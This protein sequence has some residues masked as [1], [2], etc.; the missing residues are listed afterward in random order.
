MR[1]KAFKLLKEYNSSPSLIKHA[2]AVEGVMRYFAKKAGEDEEYWGTVGLLHDID[3]E[4]YPEEHCKK[5]IDILRDNNYSED[6]IRSITSHGYGIV[7]DEKPNLY[8]EKV[9][10]SIDEL[11][12]LITATALM[13]PSK[14]VM[15]LEVKSVK[16]KFKDKGFAASIDRNI[17]RNGSEM[18]EI[19][20]EELIEETI[21][22]MREI[23]EALEL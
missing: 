2:L 16:K 11:T 10:Y 13:R 4:K 18:L 15:D 17:I 19:T 21:S 3:Y 12:G 9:L 14:S 22:G 7:S 8:M 5:A 1:D 20:L 23:H 6:F